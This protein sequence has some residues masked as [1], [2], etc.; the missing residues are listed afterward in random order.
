M[1]A[2]WVA[3]TVR[4]R[5]LLERRLGS[6]AVAGLAVLPTPDAAAARLGD[7]SYQ[8]FLPAGADPGQAE[9]AVDDAVLWNLR[10]LAGWLP[11]RGLAAIQALASDYEIRNIADKLR[12]LA[13]EPA[14]TPYRLGALAA[15]WRSAAAARSTAELRAAVSASPWGDPGT[16]EPGDFVVFL[17]LSAASRLAAVHDDARPWGAAAAALAV[18][19]RR[20]LAGAPLSA[21]AQAKAGPLLGS[22]ALHA[23]DWPGFTAALPRRDVGWV[24][25]GIE[26]PRQLWRAEELWW[27]RLEQDAADLVHTSGFGP[28]PALGCA[29]LLLA[30]A[31]AVRAALASAARGGRS[32]GGDHAHP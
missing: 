19:R 22:P 18:A 5:A 13:G 11:R 1:G 23:E 24:L 20:F 16:E 21:T 27:S 10:V 6:A 30:D 2:G 7:S 9:R 17:R 29:A 28:E 3:G 8:R 4:A 12:V 14:G 31:R 15:A 25:E 32:A 26:D